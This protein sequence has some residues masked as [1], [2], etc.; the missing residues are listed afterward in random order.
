[1]RNILFASLIAILLTACGHTPTAATDYTA[2]VWM[3]DTAAHAPG[4]E[5]M[6]ITQPDDYSGA[7][8]CTVIRHLS[9]DTATSHGVLYVHG[10]NDYF[11][12]THLAD[13]IAS[14][15]FDFYAVDLRKYG[16]SLMPGQTPFEVRDMREYFADINAAIDVMHAAGIEHIALMG[17]S[18]GGLTTSL[19]MAL[20]PSPLVYELILNSPFLDWNLGSLECLM[21]AVTAIGKRFPRIEISQGNSSAYAESLLKQYG[22]EWTYNTEWKTVRPHPVQLGWIR[23]IHRGQR[24]LRIRHDQIKVPILLM[25]SDKS[26][27][28]GNDGDAVLDVSEIRGYGKTLSAD[29]TELEVPGGLH[30]LFLS[31]P[32]VRQT[33]YAPL[34]SFLLH[35]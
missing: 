22:G 18:T 23:A 15:G 9:A 6:Y 20:D 7:V 4:F 5:C 3:T 16:R 1:M 8:R 26:I 17:H 27:T 10:Y 35:P 12:Q 31:K 19:Y 28:A 24:M 30:D 29:V 25:Y 33:L 2:G 11:F 34:H 14:W 32:A 13:S 21:P